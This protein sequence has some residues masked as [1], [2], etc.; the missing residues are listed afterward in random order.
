MRSLA[1]IIALLWLA[2]AAAQPAPQVLNAC[3][4]VEGWSVNLAAKAPETK[5]EISTDARF[6]SEGKGCLHVATVSPKGAQGNSYLSIV[7]TTPP[8][9]M[10]GKAL[11]FEAATSDPKL[12]QALYVRGYDAKGQPVLS[13]LNWSGPLKSEKA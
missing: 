9:N 6:I 5:L 3:D 13:W 8:V 12:T 7:L 2:L 11:A 4:S 10:N 1:I